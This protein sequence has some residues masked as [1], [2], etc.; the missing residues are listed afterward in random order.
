MYTV[1]KRNVKSQATCSTPRSVLKRPT[2]ELPWAKLLEEKITNKTKRKVEAIF[3]YR[4]INTT[5]RSKI[6]GEAN[7][8]LINMRAIKILIGFHK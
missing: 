1:Q 6:C 3:R 8:V 4:W 7:S 5:Y 2:E